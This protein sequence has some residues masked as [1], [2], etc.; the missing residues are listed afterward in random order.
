MWP[1]K[2]VLR[3]LSSITLAVILLVCVAIY[4]ISASVP[5]GLMVLGLTYTLYGVTLLLTIALLA[6][7]PA[8]LVRHAMAAK[9]GEPRRVVEFVVPFLALLVLAPV[10]VMLWYRYAWPAMHFD[11][12]TG[13]GLQLFASFVKEYKSVTLRRLPGVE[14]SE[15][16]YY[17]W[18]PLRVILLL[19][20]VNMVTATVRRIDF[21]FKNI[22]VLT[23]HTGIV[24]IALG[25]IYY[26]GLKL[27]GD[28]LLL[29]GQVDAKTGTPSV[30]PAQDVFYDNTDV[31]LWVTQD[32]GW[33][34]RQLSGVPRYN[35]YNLAAISGDSAWTI[36]RRQQPWIAAADNARELSINAP[37]KAASGGG[38][39]DDD[40]GFRVVGY[41]YY[42][43][44]VDD[45]VRV[46]TGKRQVITD[47]MPDNPLRVVFLHS[48]LPDEAG[49]VSEEDP[50]FAYTFL[51]AQPAQ[52][53]STRFDGEMPVLSVEYTLGARSFGPVAPGMTQE[54]W[55]D[56]S[57][58]LPTDTTH[59]LVIEVPG[60]NGGPPT[61]QVSSVT[62]GATVMVGETGFSIRV[63]ELLAKPPFPIITKGYEKASSGVAVLQ[64]QPPQGG[65]QT[66]NEGKPFTRYV[67][68]RFPEL[69]QDILGSKEDGRPIRIDAMPG[70]RIALI[71]SNHLTIY[72]DEPQGSDG[73]VRAIVRQPGGT[74]K[75]FEALVNEPASSTPSTATPDDSRANV[76]LW[77]RNAVDKLSFRVGARWDHAVKVD[78]PAPVPA[79]E[80]N[81]EDVG[82]HGKAMMAVEVTSTLAN[83]QGWKQIVWLPFSR[84]M[85]MGIGSERHIEAPDGRVLTL[86]FGRTVHRFPNFALRLIDFEMI[87]YDHR[88][89][90]RDYQSI[91]QV[92]PV[93]AT[94]AQFDHVTKLNEPLMAPFHWSSDR[95]WMANFFG[96]LASGLSPFQFKL[97]QAG[98]DQ[99]GWSQTQKQADAGQVP[100]PFAKFT[101]LGVGNNPGIHVVALGGI[102][103][104]LGIPWAFYVKPW[105]VQRE[106]RRLQEMHRARMTV[107]TA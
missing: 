31:S 92:S 70:I 30:G 71:E 50:V 51:P 14:M 17:S 106:K 41:C 9:P 107:A 18:W 2:Q 98:W 58:Q 75:V 61:R 35:N 103:M 53:I 54:R 8:L 6:G 79:I 78:R 76:N 65:T 89:S 94:F 74:V 85:G 104:G 40:L 21:I 45:W 42:A 28:T 84:Y 3:A 36:A 39:V 86:A 55:R 66:V 11:P 91:V 12:A 1:I 7:V 93:D 67:Y 10:A 72:F 5:V 102:L 62:P 95:S 16:E 69:N 64:V 87:S 68:A 59:A 101:I 20:V 22:G 48:G 97:S 24:T 27:E 46:E 44:P 49:V 29:A 43:S 13:K 105:L 47:R 88:G 99:S 19:F 82:T 96:R 33:E 38:L 32:R 77:L 90:P 57:E 81:K 56:L 34:Q 83:L 23:V 100:R 60:S 63:Q 37:Q 26:S 4:G 15:L 80:Q 25:S 52:R 73:P